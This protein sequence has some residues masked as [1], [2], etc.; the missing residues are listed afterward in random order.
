MDA[1][2]GYKDT[3]FNPHDEHQSGKQK[4]GESFFDLND[5]RCVR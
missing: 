1:A 2:W 3:V 5:Q 4:H